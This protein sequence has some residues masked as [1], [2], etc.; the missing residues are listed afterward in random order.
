MVTT[1]NIRGPSRNRGGQL[2]LQS[3]GGDEGYK[4]CLDKRTCSCPL[5]LV[6]LKPCKHLNALGIYTKV[7]PFEP[8]TYPSFSQALSGMV[9]SIRLRRQKDA[10]YW[11]VYLDTFK[12]PQARFRTAR[13]ILIGSAEDGHSIP[14]MEKVVDSF[15]RISKSHA[16]LEELA[17][18]IMRTCR[19][20]NWWQPST[21]GPDYIYSGMVGE[22]RLWQLKMEC[23]AEN[24]MNMLEEAI[25]EQDKAKAL[26]A[27]MGFSQC[28]LGGTKQAE[29]MLECAKKASHKEAQRLATVHLSAKTALSSDNNFICQA[30]WMLA[31]GASPVADVV[32]PMDHNEVL[33][34]LAQARERWKDPKP[35][36]GWCCDGTHCAGNDERFMGVWP[37]MYAVC[38]AYEHYGRVDP[39]DEW[40]PEFQC[41]DALTIR[42]PESEGATEIAINCTN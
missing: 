16:D 2:L 11:L 32:E 1:T 22:R 21:G 14:V 29:L 4:I 5:F 26:S 38:R 20:P 30:A 18:E 36:P 8:R 42:W 17:T 15:R 7:R 23:S 37:R 24:F 33:D 40:L 27:A 31:G 39:E 41:F 6:T 35:I 12:E 13:R 28:R 34:L 25:A 9:K 10:V 19:I 3:F